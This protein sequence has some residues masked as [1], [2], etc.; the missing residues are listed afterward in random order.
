MFSDYSQKSFVYSAGIRYLGAMSLGC[1][2]SEPSIF[3][4]LTMHNTQ[5]AINR[6]INTNNT[7]CA[8]HSTRYTYPLN[9]TQHTAHHTRR[10]ISKTQDTGHNTEHTIH[11]TPYTAYDTRLRK[12]NSQYRVH[13]A[14]YKRRIHNVQSTHNTQYK[15]HNTQHTIHN[16][17]TYTIPITPLKLNLIKRLI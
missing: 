1:A 10:T 11:K 6:D 15:I 16:H 13:I 9:N 5:S 4:S 12:E 7:Q 14:Q 17:N 2:L 8:V 3:I